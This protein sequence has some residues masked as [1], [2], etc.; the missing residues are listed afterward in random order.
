MDNSHFKVIPL[1]GKAGGFDCYFGILLYP[2]AGS[3]DWRNSEVIR[4]HRS[5]LGNIH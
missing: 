1:H 3:E 5:L 2:S 4:R